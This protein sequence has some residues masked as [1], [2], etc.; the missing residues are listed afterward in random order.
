MEGG[1]LSHLEA[2]EDTRRHFQ[3]PVNIFRFGLC[4]A[5]WDKRTWQEK[6][7]KSQVMRR[8]EAQRLYPG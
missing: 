5:T 6:K 7:E 1:K 8:I 2:F 3:A 4:D